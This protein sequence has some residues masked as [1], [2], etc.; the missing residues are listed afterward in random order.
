MLKYNDSF[1]IIDI[2]FSRLVLH[3]IESMCGLWL[4]DVFT[5]EKWRSYSYKHFKTIF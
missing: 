2:E 5:L 1:Y 4:K 3:N